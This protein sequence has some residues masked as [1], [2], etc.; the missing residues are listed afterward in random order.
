MIL[1]T[2]N[3]ITDDNAD[4][5]P[6]YRWY[7]WH[8]AITDDTTQLQMTQ[9]NYRWQ[10][11]ITDDNADTQPNY[12]WHGWCTTQLQMILPTQPNYRW[13]WWQ[14]PTTDDT[15]N[16]SQLQMIWLTQPNYRWYDRHHNSLRW[17]GWHPVFQLV[18][19][20]RLFTEFLSVQ[21]HSSL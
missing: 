10:N 6:K 12:R 16:K 5:Q 13:H 8:N 3:P 20:T 2:H 19:L 1:L 7:H 11:P 18:I 21:I 14:I 15:A 9:P 17:Y 4:T